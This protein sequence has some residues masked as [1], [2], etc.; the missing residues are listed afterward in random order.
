MEPA[1][2][3]SASGGGTCHTCSRGLDTAAFSIFL[4]SAS[5][6]SFNGGNEKLK[7]RV[8][9]FLVQVSA[10]SEPFGIHCMVDI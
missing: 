6:R 3:R 9:N 10:Q 7:R 1:P 2:R 5:E 8:V 4:T